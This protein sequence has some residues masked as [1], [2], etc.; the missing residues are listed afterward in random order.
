MLSG[1]SLAELHRLTWRQLAHLYDKA[2]S[3]AYCYTLPAAYS[4]NL[5]IIKEYLTPAGQPGTPIAQKPAAR[6][7]IGQRSATREEYQQW[8]AAE[9]DKAQP[10]SDETWATLHRMQRHY[11]HLPLLTMDE[12][13]GQ[14]SAGIDVG[15]LSIGAKRAY[16]ILG[17]E[18]K[19]WE[20]SSIQWASIAALPKTLR[21][22]L[23]AAEAATKNLGKSA[24]STAKDFLSSKEK[25]MPP[26]A[27]FA[28][29][30]PPSARCVKLIQKS[31]LS[32]SATQKR[33]GAQ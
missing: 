5:D 19:Y 3:H 11:D 4:C 31:A 6:T 28:N 21:M 24:K 33:H 29:W 9:H 7:G 1:V 17:S 14:G 23:K 12:M 20:I 32:W 27:N 30:T 26:P 16:S 10:L 8:L 18:A 22:K 15:S 25:L 13:T 2:I